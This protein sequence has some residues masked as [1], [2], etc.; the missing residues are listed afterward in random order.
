MSEI[1]QYKTEDEVLAKRFAESGQ[2]KDVKTVE[3]ALVRLLFG[4]DMGL[5]PTES[6]SVHIIEGRPVLTAGLMATAIRRSGK[7]WFEC[8]TYTETRVVVEFYEIVNGER[9]L[10]GD[11]IEWTIEMARRNGYTNRPVWKQHPRAMLRSRAI[12]E[13]Y[14]TYCP[15]A[16]GGAPVYADDELEQRKN[17]KVLHHTPEPTPANADQICVVRELLEEAA[18][19]DPEVEAN[20][21]RH[22]MGDGASVDHLNEVDAAFAILSLRRKIKTHTGASK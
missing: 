13:G 6:M 5:T 20:M 1:V 17:V 4:R 2:W 18:K 21:M 15:D 16:L 7:Y 8:T 12:S 11:P 10:L 9:V 3:I 19:F 22:L 14:K